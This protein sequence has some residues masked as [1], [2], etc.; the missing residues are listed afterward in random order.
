MMS[1]YDEEEV[2]RSYIRSERY[3]AEQEG[4]RRGRQEGEQIGR[5]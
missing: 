1:L 3:E 2:L 5:L 4:E